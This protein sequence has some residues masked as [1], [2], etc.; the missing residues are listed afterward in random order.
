MAT[1]AIKKTNV[2]RKGSE[3]GKKKKRRHPH[4]CWIG[5]KNDTATILDTKR[6][7][8]RSPTQTQVLKAPK[9]RDNEK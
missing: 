8:S 7:A 3:Q 6:K 4:A 2:K 9:T 5:K 1:L